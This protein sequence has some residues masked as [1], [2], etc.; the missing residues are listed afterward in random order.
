MT[1][2]E[3][4]DDIAWLVR[5]KI[6]NTMAP[7]L[8][9]EVEAHNARIDRLI[10]LAS[11]SSLENALTMTGCKTEEGLIDMANI[12][13]SFM[14]SLET[15][16]TMDGP[17]KGWCP[18]EDPAEL[19]LDL[20]NALDEA[21]E[22]AAHEAKPFGHLVDHKLVPNPV[23]IPNG[24]FVPDGPNYI[25]TPLYTA[26]AR[27]AQQESAALVEAD[28]GKT[29]FI[30]YWKAMGVPSD[31]SAFDTVGNTM[32][33][34][35]AAVEE[36]V[37]SGA[38]GGGETSGKLV[39]TLIACAERF[40]E[41]AALHA[42]KPDME[43]ARRNSE[44]ADMCLTA[45]GDHCAPARIASGEGSEAR[46]IDVHT[47]KDSAY[48]LVKHK[49]WKP[50]DNISAHGCVQLM[51]EFARSFD[52]AA[53]T[54]NYPDC[55]CDFDAVCGHVEAPAPLSVPAGRRPMTSGEWTTIVSSIISE[56]DRNRESL[57]V[58]PDARLAFMERHGEKVR[59]LV[60]AFAAAPVSPVPAGV[61]EL[62]E[63]AKGVV[64]RWDSPLW[65]KDGGAHTADFQA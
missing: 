24:S 57:N 19:V 56:W 48:A 59:A 31:G 20:L 6:V 36:A 12:G 22:A 4:E 30:A 1:V 14:N 41:Y 2:E 42:A 26:V 62:I 38:Q 9:P 37:A 43:K 11:G 15:V 34:A 23:F 16:V 29:A 27:G 49:G 44:M 50:G 21:L 63:A 46:E 13:Q 51:V 8:R 65:A 5:S 35:W 55:G 39:E 40:T 53:H 7:A 17:F 18:A 64:N 3:R 52:P 47:A 33:S 58:Q 60:A 10:S 25:V 54:C 45:I 32:R 61:G 28:K